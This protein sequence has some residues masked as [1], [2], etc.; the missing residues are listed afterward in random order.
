MHHAVEKMHH[1]VEQMHPVETKRPETM[2][3]EVGKNKRLGT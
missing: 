1:V 3:V 2:K